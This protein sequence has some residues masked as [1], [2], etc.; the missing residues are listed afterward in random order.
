MRHSSQWTQ[1]G[2]TALTLVLASVLLLSPLGIGAAQ[3]QNQTGRPVQFM[4]PSSTPA[5]S[6]SK[7]AERPPASTGSAHST[8]P[9]RNQP[10]SP[11]AVNAPPVNDL[12]AHPIAIA[13]AP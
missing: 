3:G 2:W 7:P 9:G 6:S 5:R 4:E 1:V 12:F 13:G 8:V 11:A 10:A